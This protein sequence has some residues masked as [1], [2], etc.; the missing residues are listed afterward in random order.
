MSTRTPC[1]R[2]LPRGRPN[3][4]T[5]ARRLYWSRVS[6]LLL[7][8]TSRSLRVVALIRA[9]TQQIGDEGVRTLTP[10][11]APQWP[12]ARRSDRAVEARPQIK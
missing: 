11:C 10:G 1:C 6:H 7:R 5:P 2:A 3:L 9:T 12:R 4:T 8:R